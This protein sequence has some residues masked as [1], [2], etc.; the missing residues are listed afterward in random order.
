MKKINRPTAFQ[1]GFLASS[2]IA[3][4][5]QAL[6]VQLSYDSSS[7]YFQSGDLLSV[8]ATIFAT[9]GL[10]CGAVGVFIPKKESA[11]PNIFERRN[12]LNPLA[13][14]AIVATLL[15]AGDRLLN[16]DF[17]KSFTRFDLC[18]IL[19]LLVTV[20]YALLSGIQNAAGQTTLTAFFGLFAII[21]CILLNAYYYFDRSIEMNAPLKTSVQVGLLFTMLFL[22]SEIR[23][24]LDTP[25]PRMMQLFALGTIAFGSLSVL[26]IPVAF[27]TGKL[28]RLDYLAGAILVLG[29]IPTAIIRLYTL[30][31]LPKAEPTPP[32]EDQEKT[33]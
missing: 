29:V 24:L 19:C 4:I 16:A 30:N 18:L 23:Y 10:I 21:A 6:A 9:L 7:H 15:F 13:A 28:S 11:S 33:E 32:E 8:F 3:A 5:L 1:L 12:F 14:G 26:A 17:E 2:L 31:A 20:A 25:M 27:F 22:T